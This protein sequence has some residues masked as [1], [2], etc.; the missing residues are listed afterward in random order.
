MPEGEPLVNAAR[1]ALAAA[2][3]AAALLL[4]GCLGEQDNSDAV[5][6]KVVRVASTKTLPDQSY[7]EC[8]SPAAVF[9]VQVSDSK[10]KEMREGQVC[11]NGK[12]IS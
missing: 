6:G 11:P 5:I 12:R 4:S 8:V 9:K 7:V 10:I 1:S 2:V 3:C